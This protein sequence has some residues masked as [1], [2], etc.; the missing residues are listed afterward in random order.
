LLADSLLVIQAEDG[1]VVLVEATPE[2][3]RELAAFQ[4]IEGKTWNIP[5][6]AGRQ[7]FVRNDHE[8]AC[9]ELPVASP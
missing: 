1:R 8:A 2:E 9:Y 7:L 3:H 5:A 6:L 4:T